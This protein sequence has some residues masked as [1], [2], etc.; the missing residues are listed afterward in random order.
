M[1][2]YTRSNISKVCLWVSGLRCI[3]MVKYFLHELATSAFLLT[4]TFTS[5]V[6]QMTKRDS[7]TC[8]SIASEKIDG[9]RLNQKA[10]CHNKGQVHE[11]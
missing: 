8:I 6:A 1:R 2:L 7:M 5:L 3:Q 11:V 4:V 10:K 9:I